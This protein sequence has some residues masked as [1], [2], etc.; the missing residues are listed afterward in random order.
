MKPV[1]LTMSAFGPYAEVASVDFRTFG[2][3]GLFLVT[4]D[5]GAGKTTIFDGICYALF[6]EASGNL[7]DGTM[8]RSD[9]AKP[10]T[11]TFVELTFL[12]RGLSYFV[13][14]NPKYERPKTRGEGMTVENADA[15]LQLPDP[16]APNGIRVVSGSR[17]VTDEIVRILG[18]DRNQFTQIA[19]LAQGD[20]LKIL[21]GD[22]RERSEIFRKVFNT[23]RY[24]R[25]QNDLKQ[26]VARL[27]GTYEDN[28]RGLLQ[29]AREILA[30][31]GHEREAE[32]TLLLAGDD[33][34]HRMDWLL[35]TLASFVSSDASAWEESELVRK[36]QEAE[37][38]RL[39]VLLAGAVE[40][41]A[42]LDRAGQAGRVLSELEERLPAME[43]KTRLRARAETARSEVKPLDLR[44]KASRQKVQETRGRMTELEQ[45]L[46]TGKPELEALGLRLES[47]RAREPER[48]FWMNEIHAL[49]E[50]LPRHDSLATLRKQSET[51]GRERTATDARLTSLFKDRTTEETRGT[52]LRE[53][54]ERLKDAPLKLEQSRHALEACRVRESVL[55]QLRERHKEWQ[56]DT[57]KLETAQKAF[58][59]A[60]AKSD[61]SA[62]EHLRLES[63]FLAEQAGL[64]AERL[65]EGAACPVC[66]SAEHPTP[67]VKTAD[68]PSEDMLR[69]ARETSGADRAETQRKSESAAALNAAAQARWAQLAAEATG[70]IQPV[71]DAQ[72]FELLVNES[73]QAEAAELLA[74]LIPSNIALAAETRTAAEGLVA[75]CEADTLRNSAIG[76]EEVKCRTRI[77]A[78]A[79]A[80]E[81]ERSTL[82][83]A[84]KSLE[85]LRAQMEMI[86]TSLRHPDKKAAEAAHKAM[87]KRL[88]DS[89]SAL[90]EAEALLKKRQ[91]ELARAEAAHAELQKSAVVEQ[92]QTEADEETFQAALARCGFNGLEAYHES[93]MSDESLKAL[94]REIDAHRE[95]LVRARA[96]CDLLARETAGLTKQDTAALEGILAGARQTALAAEVRSRD[97]YSRL[98]RN[99]DIETSLLK[100]RRGMEE[101]EVRYQSLKALSDTANGELKGKQRLA[102]ERYIQAAWFN[103]VLVLANE[104]FSYMT[105]RRYEL[106]RREESTDLRGQAGLELDVMDHYTGKARSVKSLSGGESFKASLSLALGLSDMIQHHTGGVQLD[107]MF[108]DEGFGT[109]DAESLEQAIDI[110]G[111]LTG[112]DR[113]VGIISHVAELRER[114]DR[115]I[116]VTR[117][118]SGSLVECRNM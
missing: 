19:M 18:V 90:T 77:A 15:E 92:R 75:S 21:V 73:G 37:S 50:E 40:T 36:R 62:A 61:A 53:E 4:G 80:V 72:R 44:L 23:K 49:T 7:R 6:D 5:T 96:D 41:N 34:P 65:V 109:L 78:L 25:F 13:R 68:A 85:G 11:R 39:E 58:R 56:E 52:S 82:A 55:L 113:F 46:M 24:E 100:R 32:L 88:A 107:T 12:Y 33:V 60:L 108:V 71:T 28:R 103:R 104:R 63:A 111:R 42:K 83:E 14:R 70:C 51:I 116:I 84:D 106:V 97:L 47:E 102:F 29:S 9:F 110:L 93:L 76:D 94:I 17:R 10:E 69:R 30:P 117:G 66:G 98:Q 81:A 118:V 8:M 101:S 67:A 99:R 3:N 31:S 16:S 57:K 87:E 89:K 114:I 105:N 79:S 20:F 22:G 48:E 1:L 91:E 59:K 115:K 35:E 86:A 38:T 27:R 112:G 45:R 54:A 43:E 2:E 74:Q 64:L 26:Q 95:A